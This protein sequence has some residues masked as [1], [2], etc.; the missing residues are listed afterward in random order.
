[1]NVKAPE[2]PRTNPHLGGHDSYAKFT[3]PQSL[4][5]RR[6]S[7]QLQEDYDDD[8]NKDD[9]DADDD[10]DDDDDNASILRL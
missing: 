4:L 8:D 9:D 1:M 10:N 2:P 7:S 3:C 6:C 5:S